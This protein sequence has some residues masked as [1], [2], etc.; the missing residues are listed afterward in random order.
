MWTA[1]C[2]CRNSTVCFLWFLSQQQGIHNNMVRV[3]SIAKLCTTALLAYTVALVVSFFWPFLGCCD[4]N[5][6]S[7]RPLSQSS[8]AF[9]HGHPSS[10]AALCCKRVSWLVRESAQTAAAT[11]LPPTLSALPYKTGNTHNPLCKLCP[12]GNTYR[13]HINTI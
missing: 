11:G 6:K 9:L 1:Y 12:A 5:T 2:L 4:K 8:A 7:L 3:A 13:Q 10:G